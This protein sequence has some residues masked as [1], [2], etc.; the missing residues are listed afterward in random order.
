[1]LLATTLMKTVRR[2]KTHR[3]TRI[4]FLLAAGYRPIGAGRPRHNYK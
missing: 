3:S 4:S 1:L 2:H